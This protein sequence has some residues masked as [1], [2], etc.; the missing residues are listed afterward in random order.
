MAKTSSGESKHCAWACMH[1]R[2]ES[3]GG[4]GEMVGQRSPE[5]SEVKPGECV[6]A[7]I[8]EPRHMDGSYLEVVCCREPKYLSEP[9][10]VYRVSGR[11]TIDDPDSGSV[12]TP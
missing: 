10:H 6:G 5:T 9:V 3:Y 12:V 8:S 4:T 1:G 11:S 7:G 2:Y